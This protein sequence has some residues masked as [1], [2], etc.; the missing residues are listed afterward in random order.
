MSYNNDDIQTMVNA[1]I[2]AV[3]GGSGSGGRRG[4]GRRGGRGSGSGDRGGIRK[5]TR[6]RCYRVS[7]QGHCLISPLLKY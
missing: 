6:S 4:G 5:D 7:S 2:S 1:A 3:T